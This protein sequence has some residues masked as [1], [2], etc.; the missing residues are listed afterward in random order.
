MGSRGSIQEDSK[1]E[2]L[3]EKMYLDAENDVFVDGGVNDQNVYF[4]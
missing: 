3:T 4:L 1:Q 2:N